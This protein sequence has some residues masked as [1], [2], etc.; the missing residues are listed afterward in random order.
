[1]CALHYEGDG[2][3]EGV[4]PDPVEALEKAVPEPMLS[5]RMLPSSSSSSSSS[6]PTSSAALPSPKRH[7]SG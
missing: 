3:C 6:A 2:V 7:F 5:V 1:M 4:N